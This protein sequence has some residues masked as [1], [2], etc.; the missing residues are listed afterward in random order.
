[1]FA[2]VL[3]RLEPGG[4]LP[5]SPPRPGDPKCHACEG[6]KL[7]CHTWTVPCSALA[8]ERRECEQRLTQHPQTQ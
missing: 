5:C 1:V 8:G 3:R 4:W 6:R 7:P 2:R